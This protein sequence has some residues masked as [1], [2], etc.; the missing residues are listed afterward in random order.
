M[1]P[2]NIIVKLDNMFMDP[3]TFLWVQ[4]GQPCTLYLRKPQ[5]VG[6]TFVSLTLANEATRQF[7]LRAQLKCRCVYYVNN[8]IYY[9]PDN[10]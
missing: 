5:T 8:Q 1:T 3:F 6:Y 9:L 2:V 7:L 10:L 4:A